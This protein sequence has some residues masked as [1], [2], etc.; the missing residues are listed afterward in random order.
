MTLGLRL[1]WGAWRRA[2]GQLGSSSE[3]QG[4][5]FRPSDS[6]G[7]RD[8]YRERHIMR[9]NPV[10]LEQENEGTLREETK[11]IECFGFDHPKGTVTKV[12]EEGE[13]VAQGRAC[14]VSWS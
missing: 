8:A 4:A 14:R 13:Q 9:E 6:R 5:T 1:A 7:S 11:D 2:G 3:N 12:P 10:S